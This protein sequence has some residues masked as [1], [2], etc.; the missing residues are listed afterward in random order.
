MKKVS[1]K[2][3]NFIYFIDNGKLFF[4]NNENANILC[5]KK[6]ILSKLIFNNFIFTEVDTTY[7]NFSSQKLTKEQ[8]LNLYI[9]EIMECI[10]LN[11]PK[12]EG[13]HTKI[14][15]R[16]N[17]YGILNK[18]IL[19]VIEKSLWQ[20]CLSMYE[21]FNTNKVLNE[22]G[23]GWEY[24]VIKN[25]NYVTK[26]P[27]NCFSETSSIEYL[28]DAKI[29]YLSLRD[30]LGS[31]H[32]AETK[33]YRKNNQNTIIQVYI[34]TNFD[35]FLYIN[36]LEKSVLKKLYLFLNLIFEYQKNKIW[37]P[38]FNLKLIKSKL[39]YNNFIIDENNSL[40]KI[41]DFT[42]YYDPYRLYPELTKKVYKDDRKKLKTIL[43]YLKNKI[44]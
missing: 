21:K 12:S 28:T 9:T 41:I 18:S 32:I 37:M 44:I 20:L 16:L 11:F 1:D 39:Y 42:Y 8:Y 36:K 30:K 25:K 35:N 15:Y 17:C 6:I 7:S 43:L 2:M 29:S 13:N 27:K 31:D 40:P 24:I 22:I 10:G 14:K 19:W 38:D 33:F 3:F 5:Y 26:H 4:L 34:K 23:S